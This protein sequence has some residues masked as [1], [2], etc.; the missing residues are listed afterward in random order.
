MPLMTIKSLPLPLALLLSGC[1]AM[2]DPGPEDNDPPLSDVDVLL[3]GAPDNDSLPSEGKADAVYPPLHAELVALQSPV[4]SQGSR[5][6]C[7]IFSTVALMEHLYLKEGSFTNPDFSEQFLQWSVKFEVGAF[8][9][10]S[11]SNADYNLQ[12]INRFG[13]VDEATYPYQSYQW[14]TA[15]DPACTGADDQPTRCYTNGEPPDAVKNA[16][17]YKL[18]PGRYLNTNSIKAHIS[19]KKTAVVIGA[20]FFYQAWN[21]RKSELPTNS[22]Y[23]RRGIVLYP[24]EKDKELSLAKRAGHSVPIVGWDDDLEV[25]VV[26]EHGAQ[27]LDAEGQPVVEKGFYIFKNSWGTGGFG[28]DNP[29]GNG[30]GYLSQRYVREYGSAYVSAEPVID[31]DE[32]CDD[33]QD[34][35]R[36]G[37]TDCDDADCA[38]QPACQSPTAVYTFT[39]EQSAAIP[40]N[41]PVGVSTTIDIPG[42]ATIGSLAVTVD[43]SHSYSG[44]VRVVLHRGSQTVVLQDQTGG[45]AD[46][47]KK[48]F[49]VT[50]FTGT[51]M[52]GSWTLTV[53]DHAA[54]DTGNLNG[55]SMEIHAQ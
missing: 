51:D 19:S 15:N 53:T 55:W 5:G 38:D 29:H 31:H 4:K 7:S 41:D 10:T 33:D 21:H 12:A 18:P 11:G 16:T 26:D 47:I 50:D 48:T 25:P 23:W 43:I 8:P 52:T 37:D 34:N 6:V 27:V 2:D 13:I 54:Y 24:N 14:G 49:T 3:G 17:R 44:D 1:I 35:D 30:Y 9:N 22:D 40:D 36:D 45:Y 28:V 20:T 39:S 46:D 32:I 42:S